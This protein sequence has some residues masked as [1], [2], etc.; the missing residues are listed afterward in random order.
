MR[1]DVK[2]SWWCACVPVTNAGKFSLLAVHICYL[3]AP[4]ITIE[5]LLPR[6]VGS[7]LNDRLSTLAL[8]W[9]RHKIPGAQP[10][11]PSGRF[12]KSWQPLGFPITVYLCAS[13]FNE[14]ELEAHVLQLATGCGLHVVQASMEYNSTSWS[15]ILHTSINQVSAP[16]SESPFAGAPSI[17]QVRAML[18]KATLGTTSLEATTHLADSAH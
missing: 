16:N 18:P 1:R 17:R 4:R 5:C 2:S 12:E 14:A 3:S 8:N 7:S 13:T 9:V 6:Q 11:V 15:C 10:L